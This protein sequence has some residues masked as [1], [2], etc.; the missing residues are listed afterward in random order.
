MRKFRIIRPLTRK[1][2]TVQKTAGRMR[3]LDQS[4]YAFGLNATPIQGRRVLL[5]DDVVTTGATLQAAARL[6]KDAGATVWVATLA[7]QPLD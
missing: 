5:I 3:R 2:T 4:K 1:T 7:Y 6:L